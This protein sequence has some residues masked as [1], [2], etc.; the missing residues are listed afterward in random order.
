VHT[1]GELISYCWWR[2]NVARAIRKLFRAS[3][4]SP[5]IG[6][7]ARTVRRRSIWS[8]LVMLSCCEGA[9]SGRNRDIVR[10]WSILI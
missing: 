1:E 8:Y 10:R 2:L 3:N 4:I 6:E 7:S 5:F 9:R